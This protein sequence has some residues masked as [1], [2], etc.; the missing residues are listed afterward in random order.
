VNGPQGY[1]GYWPVDF[2][3]ANPFF[4]TQDDMASL[5]TALSENS[6]AG[7]LDVV[8][9]HVGY[10]TT[11]PSFQYYMNPFNQ[12][13]YYHNCSQC[14]DPQCSAV[15]LLKNTVTP[16]D[17]QRMLKCQL[18][19]LPDLDHSVPFVADQ[20][21]AWVQYLKANFK[22]YGFRYDAASFIDPLF[23]RKFAQEAQLFGLEEI[24]LTI[25]TLGQYDVIKTHLEAG[26]SLLRTTNST[27]DGAEAPLFSTLDFPFAFALRNCFAGDDP[28]RGCRQIS[29]VRDQYRRIG[30]DQSLMGRFFDNHDIPRFLTLNP[31]IVALKNAM[32]VLMLGQGIPILFQGT[33]QGMGINPAPG[34]GEREPVWTTGFGTGGELYIYTRMLNWYRSLLQLW[35]TE[36]TELYVDDTTYIFSRDGRV[37]VVATNGNGTAPSYALK[38]LPAAT[39]FCSATTTSDGSSLCVTTADDGSVTIVAAEGA[40]PLIFI[41]PS[42]NRSWRFFTPYTHWDAEWQTG[43]ILTFSILPGAALI[44]YLLFNFFPKYSFDRIMK[45]NDADALGIYENEATLRTMRTFKMEAG[46]TLPPMDLLSHRWQIFEDEETCNSEDEE[47][48]KPLTTHIKQNNLKAIEETRFQQSSSFQMPPML[49]SA[50]GTCTSSS[51]IALYA[52]ALKS[53]PNLVWHLTL[54]YSIPHL[55]HASDLMFGGLGKVVDMF[56]EFST[57]PIA[58]CAP[59]YAPFYSEDG[60]LKENALGNTSQ[61]LTTVSITAGSETFLV[62]VFLAVPDETAPR[63]IFYFLL[64]CPEIFGRKTRGTIY[65]FDTEKDQMQFFSVY[66]QAVAFSIKS[67][68]VMCVQMHDNHAAL[69]LQYLSPDSRPLVLVVLHNGDYDTHFKLGTSERDS[70]VYQQLNLPMDATTRLG[71][72]HLGAV[73]FLKILATHLKETQCGLGFVAVSPRYALRCYNKFALFWSL[74][75]QKFNGILNGMDEKERVNAIPEDFEAFFEEKARAKESLQRR[76][77]LEVGRDK[78]LLVFMGRIAHQ[79]G[80]DLISLAAPAILRSNPKAQ[81]VVGGP[82]GDRNGSFAALKLQKVAEKFPGRVWNAAGTYIA[83]AEKEELILATDFFFSPS[84]FEPCGLADIEMGWMGAVQIGHNTGGLGKM[85]GF[86]FEGGLDNIG[87]LSARLE[88]VALKALATAPET[89]KKMAMEAILSTFPPEE[90]IAKYDV[91]WSE[92]FAARTKAA[93]AP[94]LG[95]KESSFFEEAWL[96]DNAVWKPSNDTASAEKESSSSMRAWWSNAMLILAQSFFQAPALLAM[97]WVE[98]IIESGTIQT[99]LHTSS[100]LNTAVTLL[101]IKFGINIVSAPIW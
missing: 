94:L 57:R 101:F 87:D 65:S 26:N 68:G 64:G 10:G 69:S 6:I 7:I 84:R 49:L 85:P 89:L 96:A 9:N 59:M 93:A 54:E 78:L 70:Y 52:A 25:D 3:K 16:E 44:G 61:F 51:P 80:V 22:I 47:V 20:F 27:S 1:H 53:D 18:S 72:E 60:K 29:F 38:G 83:G 14:P 30:A 45:R 97:L 21:L 76:V 90:M 35:E 31:D 19:S 77:G 42:W 36:M 17:W 34:F 43:L 82:I 86:Y 24:Y 99:P 33:E 66:N 37:I 79:K 88:T 40:E 50:L 95:E 81:I 62:D 55:G 75:R 73:D 39:E 11:Y 15:F 28:T 92:L 4:G 2:Y 67:F 13:S 91:E 98:Y 58:V 41:A 56:G 12:E 71:I 100:T 8:L 5:F 48:C 74:P 63:N 32:A 23:L 46:D